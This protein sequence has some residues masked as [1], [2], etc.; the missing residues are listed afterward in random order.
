MV[1]K[2]SFTKTKYKIDILQDL[3][4]SYLLNAFNEPNI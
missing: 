1:L 3:D 4:S 2:N